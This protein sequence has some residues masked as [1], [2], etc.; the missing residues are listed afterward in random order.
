MTANASHYDVSLQLSPRAGEL[1]AEVSLAYLVRTAAEKLEFILHRSLGP[2]A[3]TGD[4][5]VGSD[6]ADGQSAC[7]FIT[8][9]ATVTVW[10]GRR[11]SP[12]EVC[13]LR[14]TYAG[15]PGIASKWE[16]NR[17][18]ADWVEL[19]LY[20]PWYPF[21]TDEPGTYRV[22]LTIDEPY[23]VIGL[24]MTERR[25]DRWLITS[26]APQTDM[27]L[28]AAPQLRL[29]ERPTAVGPVAVYCAATADLDYAARLA[30]DCGAALDWYGDWLGATG[31]LAAKPTMV[32]V[33]RVVGGAYVRPGLVVMSRPDPASKPDPVRSFGWVA[34]EMAH[35]WWLMAPTSTW[36]DWLNESFAEFSALTAIRRCFG[37]D[38]FA[39]RL[40]AMRARCEGVPPI[41][42]LPRTHEQAHPALYTKGPV[43][44]A[45]LEALIGRDL[46]TEF[47]RQTIERRVASTADLLT[48][49]AGVADDAAAASLDRGLHE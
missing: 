3:V 17:L 45:D 46:M 23:D 13:R 24:G 33:P 15:H 5:V 28:M 21:R 20:A 37:D 42:G 18:T 40:A 22:A 47:L 6:W 10:L 11:Y 26:A 8:D 44:L 14:F 36:E 19:G 30:D 9:G 2:V 34:H 41:A 49:L 29:T 7:P 4:D 1:R 32:I 39:Q 25:A 27:L 31:A 35:L 16:V 43:L 38:A 48:L 12:G